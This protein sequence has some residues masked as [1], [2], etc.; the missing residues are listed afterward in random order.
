MRNYI[1]YDN[2]NHE[3]KRSIE[4]YLKEVYEESY[5]KIR[6]DKLYPNVDAMLYTIE[7]FCNIADLDKVEYLSTIMYIKY[8]GRLK[9]YMNELIEDECYE[10]CEIMKNYL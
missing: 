3:Q 6:Y 2:R 9:E 7:Y 5:R 1:H 10:V 4:N 8:P